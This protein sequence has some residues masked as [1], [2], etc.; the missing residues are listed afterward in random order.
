MKRVIVGISGA[1]GATYGIRLLEVLRTVADVETHLVL[2]AAARRTIALETDLSVAQVKAAADRVHKA[3]DVAA[4]I[5]SG[6]FRATSMIVAPCSIK[7]AAGIATSYSDNLLL[8]AADVM[9]KERRPL[10]LLVRET[11]MHVGHL[12]LLVQ[13]AEL[14]AVIMPPVPALYHRPAT[15][16]AV[17]DQTVNRALDQ[18]GIELEQDLFPR[19][20]RDPVARCGR[21]RAFSYSAWPGTRLGGQAAGHG[22]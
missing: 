7:T 20:G 11:P 19:W 17:I 9:L 15:L 14:G 8:R 12:R 10:V 4:P 6:S 5:S 22:E 2:T 18:L 3:S 1:S 16:E 13:L 21:T